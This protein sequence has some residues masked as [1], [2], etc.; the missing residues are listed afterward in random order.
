MVSVVPALDFRDLVSSGVGA[1]GADG[2]QCSLGA[3][4]REPYLFDRGHPLAQCL[5]QPYLRLVRRAV[6]EAVRRL[7][8]DRLDNPVV[9]VTEHV[10]R[11]VEH[12]IEIA[13]PVHVRRRG[14]RPR[15]RRRTGRA[16]STPCRESFRRVGIAPP[17]P[18]APP[19]SASKLCT[20]RLRSPC[21]S[22]RLLPLKRAVP[23]RH[24][25]ENRLRQ[26]CC[27][28][29]PCGCPFP[30][31]TRFHPLMWPLQGHGHSGGGRNP[32]SPI[33]RNMVACRRNRVLLPLKRAV[34]FLLPTK[35][36]QHLIETP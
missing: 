29:N 19:T 7:I 18:E 23:I 28:G 33:S 4:I 6:A 3:R 10:G 8:S 1:C 13:V 11:R 30:A 25:S 12:E 24:S 5:C 32:V 16:Q 31:P 17:R 22:L 14:A 20:Y 36:R 21:Y 34:H 2:V 27:R 9:R 26:T 15:A 35:S